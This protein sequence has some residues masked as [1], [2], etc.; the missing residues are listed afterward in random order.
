M[1]VKPQYAQHERITPST[2][3]YHCVDVY[4]LDPKKPANSAK[5]KMVLMENGKK[6]FQL[7]ENVTVRI[8]LSDGSG[9]AKTVGGDHV[10]VWMVEPSKKASSA[11]YVID[12]GNGT[13][14][15]H[16]KALWVGIPLIRA[17]IAITCE[18]VGIRYHAIKEPSKLRGVLAV[19]KSD[20][21][22]E[23]TLCAPRLNSKRDLCNFSAENFGLPWFCFR[24]Q[25]PKLLCHDWVKV[26]GY[27]P[28]GFTQQENAI[29]RG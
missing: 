26:R 3:K 8:T 23:E 25:N 9:K 16:L 1:K 6:V 7:G 15:G 2:T 12:H 11:G 10:R 17:A 20:H 19:F 22:S 5:S 28:K 18:G 24:P 21:I 4:D 27:H 13:Y 29:L 14:T